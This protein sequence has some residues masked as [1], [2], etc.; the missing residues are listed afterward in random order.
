MKPSD[1][2]KIKQQHK[3]QQA[4]EDSQAYDTI[5]RLFNAAHDK[6]NPYNPHKKTDDQ[7]PTGIVNRNQA[8]ILAA[9][10]ANR[11]IKQI[12]NKTLLSECGSMVETLNELAR[13][14]AR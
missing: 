2:E 3:H 13:I 4:R 12:Q 7:A 10:S 6:K 11:I 8:T 5:I 9:N 14:A 1:F